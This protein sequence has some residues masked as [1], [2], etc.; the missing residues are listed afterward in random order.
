MHP[1]V[2]AIPEGVR[3]TACAAAKKYAE[4]QAKR[5]RWESHWDIFFGAHQDA[6]VYIRA[7]GGSTEAIERVATGRKLPQGGAK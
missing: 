4:A 6:I 5:A 2:A 7:H 1:H 3:F